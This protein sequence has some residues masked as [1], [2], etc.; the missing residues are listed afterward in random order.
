MAGRGGR[1]GRDDH[2]R[3][4]TLTLEEFS[5]LLQST[6]PPAVTLANGNYQVKVNGDW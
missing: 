6:D 2:G 1:T 4:Q 5:A 3:R